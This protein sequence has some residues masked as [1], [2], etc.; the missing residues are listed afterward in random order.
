[1]DLVPGKGTPLIETDLYRTFLVIA[2]TGSFSKASEVIG[3]TPS[4]VSMQ[5]KKLETLL[6]TAV[7]A[8]EGRSVRMTAEGE[9]LLGY[10]RRIL[11]L[12]EEA[13][14]M[15]RSPSIEGEVRFG[16]PSDFGTR[17]LP[18]ILTR[19]ARS[20]PAVNVD[21][22]LDGSPP[23]LQKLKDGQLDL[24]LYTARPDSDLARGGE[25]VYT[26]PLAW[27]G[28]E[29][30]VAYSRNP[31]PLALSV[32]GCPWRKAARI[33]LDKAEHPYRIAYQSFHSAGQEA[34]LLA[35]LAVAPFPTSVITPPLQKLD[36]RH[37]LPEIGD[38]HLILKEAG[39]AGKA[40]DAF[41]SHVIACF[42]E[43]NPGS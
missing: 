27:A 20:H 6:G 24:I 23:L 17:F 3:R 26:E 16:A 33:A 32:S 13:V 15:F 38:Y 5:V 41:A 18:N 29:G 28:L 25:I 37:G 2:E 14:A 8:R 43:M 7:F 12:N 30:G 31:L 39:N 34:A 35:D 36:A 9:A 10:A 40:S 4:A 1:M 22:H 11:L 21:V 19:F 42:R